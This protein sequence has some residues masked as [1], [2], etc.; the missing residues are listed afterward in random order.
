CD[1]GMV[2]AVPDPVGAAVPTPVERDHVPA[3]R[4]EVGCDQ[5]PGVG[6]LQEPVQQEQ[7]GSS[8]VAPLQDVVTQAVGDDEARAGRHRIESTTAVPAGGWMSTG[9]GSRRGGPSL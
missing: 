8:R 1:E 7:R 6:V 5:V 3:G 2:T 9:G 4:G